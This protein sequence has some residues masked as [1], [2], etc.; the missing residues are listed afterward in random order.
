[1]A[2][3]GAYIGPENVWAVASLGVGLAFLLVAAIEQRL[4]RA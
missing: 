4:Q 3:A 2:V 1:V